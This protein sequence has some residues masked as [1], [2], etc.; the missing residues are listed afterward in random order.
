MAQVRQ[1]H[2]RVAIFE[3]EGGSDKTWNGHRKDTIPIVE[4]FK[5]LGWT[6]EVIFFRDEWK[7]AITKY[8][9]ENCD[10]YI[11]RINT[12][13]LPNGEAVFNQALREMCAAGVVGT[14][15]P[16][17]LMKYDSKLSLVDLNK[18]PLS[19]A[20]TVAYFK[21][22]DLVKNFPT[23]LTNGE[24]VLKQNRGSTGE[25]IWRV[26][27]GEGVQVV[28][29]QAL[30]L[31]TKIKCTE[32]VDNHVEHHTLESFFKLCERYYKVEEN[33]I[34]DMRF[35]PR[36]KEG[37]VRIF[38]MGTKPLF[39]I[40][41]KPADKQ[42]AFSATLF[43]GAT[44]KYESPEAWP[45]LIKFFTSCLQHLTDNLGDVETILDWT[46]D[47]ILDTDENGKDKYWISE[48]N[49]SCIGFTN[50]LD[51][52]IQQEMARELVRKVL[53]KRFGINAIRD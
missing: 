28:K 31:D 13:N 15:H 29:G 18:T 22:D 14:P 36:I 43:S 5:E 47:F 11:P 33:F 6:A 53:K 42:D 10:A 38:L 23:S 19:P 17:T 25:G 27:V 20:D 35:L 26:Q 3:A 32:A 40:H 48:V 44:Y 49:V 45:E 8:V 39:V 16:D 52:G 50:Q 21:W 1:L 34:I 12:G 9:I 41:K 30:P 37:E 51:I 4:A 2:R 46:C 24:R 7:E